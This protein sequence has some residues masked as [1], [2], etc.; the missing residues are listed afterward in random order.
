M[1]PHTFTSIT[2]V[3]PASVFFVLNTPCVFMYWEHYLTFKFFLCEGRDLLDKVCNSFVL[4][5]TICTHIWRDV[6]VMSKRKLSSS[7]GTAY[8]L[9]AKEITTGC[10]NM[11][12][13]LSHSN[14]V[15][16]KTVDFASMLMHLF[17]Y[18]FLLLFCKLH[19]PGKRCA[20]Y[21]NENFPASTTKFFLFISVHIR[22]Q[23]V[24]CTYASH[25][26][27]IWYFSL[28][29]IHSNLP[30]VQ[31]TSSIRANDLHLDLLWLSLGR[32]VDCL[33]VIRFC[34]SWKKN[35]M[36]FI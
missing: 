12:E 10:F 15:L 18:M 30:S 34:F 23:V 3:W 26:E 14:I 27:T 13:M 24:Q 11:N 9:Y 31:H 1:C 7:S 16:R 28:R 22:Y 4:W 6:Y 25:R 35:I 19:I 20:V 33:S 5:D 21:L 32:A 17:M 2:I 8:V 36:I 29:F